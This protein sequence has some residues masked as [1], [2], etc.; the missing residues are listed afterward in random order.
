MAP[1]RQLLEAEAEG[2]LDEGNLASGDSD[3]V[4]PALVED[5][6]ARSKILGSNARHLTL[7][8]TANSIKGGS[9]VGV[10]PTAHLD[11][12]ERVTIT[13]DN[14]EFTEPAAV[15][16]LDYDVTQANKLG[17]CLLFANSTALS[18]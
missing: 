13:G 18:S 11:K 7:L 17:N 16:P 4:E 2:V 6:P 3:N 9:V 5:G 1:E 14:V 10:G 8:A 12:H 15:V